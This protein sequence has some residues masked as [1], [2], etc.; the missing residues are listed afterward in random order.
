LRPRLNAGKRVGSTIYLHKSA[1]LESHADVQRRVAQAELISSDSHWNVAKVQ[2]HT[3]SLLT[4]EDFETAAFPTLLS[5]TR[6]DLIAQTVFRADYSK[7]ANPPI[8][9][10]KETLLASSDPRRPKYAA[11]T[12]MA[13]EKGL[14]AEPNKIGTRNAWLGLL[15]KA[16]LEIRGA[17]LVPRGMDVPAVARHK[18]A[19][20]RRDLSQPVQLL[21]ANGIITKN[22][23]L[24][25]YG[26][27]QGDDV[28]ILNTNGY[29]AF[30]WDPYH[31]QGGR[32]GPATIVNL[33]FV[34]N[35]VEDPHER[36]EVLKEAWGFTEN[37]LSVAVMTLS[38]ANL[39]GLRPYR[40]GYLTSRGTFQ[41][42]FG[43]QELRDLIEEV[44]G[45]APVSLGPG[46]YAVFRNKELEQEVVLRR[47]S[48]ATARHFGM[49]LPQR[50]SP[51]IVPREALVERVALELQALWS[52]MLAQGRALDPDEVPP[53]LREKFAAK[54]LSQAKATE[55]CQS[56]VFDQTELANAASERRDDYLVHF[57]LTLF[58]GAPKY[59]TLPKSIQRDVRS[60]FGSHVATLSLARELLFSVGKVEN[61]RDAVEAAVECG[62]GAMRDNETFRFQAT[63]LNRLPNVL[64]VL[65]GCAA[66]LGS[67]VD[68]ADF[69]DVKLTAP[70]VTFIN[71]SDVSAKL[72][73]I[74]ERNRV[75]LNRLK[76]RVDRPEGLVFYLK[77]KFIAANDPNREEQLAFDKK[78][79]ASGLISSDGRGPRVD[80]LKAA[81]KARRSKQA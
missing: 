46:I 74:V 40:D 34:L 72:P 9:H 71:F 13:E 24:F 38:Q 53:E 1:I 45:E 33:G 5:A 61:V 69:V 68:G 52:A 2:A 11:I 14:F 43:Q 55:L 64:R 19:I 50:I 73:L 27:G 3:I 21:L 16:S 8:L 17:N 31:A 18:T 81:L 54:K 78:L 49:L 67:G 37:A 62:F 12:K 39:A 58:P 6:V 20:I 80:E 42:Y 48:R 66:L 22:C 65:V 25:D 36:I 63:T 26:C 23:S 28:T 29:Q 35:V 51:S 75:D 60:F 30:G 77:G 15:E 56:S 70:R 76:C 59:T 79:L 4:Y 7:R 41:K 47:R 57:A 32:R 44:L 10:R